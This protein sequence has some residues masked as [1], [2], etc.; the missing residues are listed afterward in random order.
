[1][2]NLLT[3]HFAAVV[4]AVV[5]AITITITVLGAAGGIIWKTGRWVGKVDSETSGV[6]EFAQEIRDNLREMRTH[7]NDIFSRLPPPRTVETGSPVR[8][9]EFGRQVAAKLQADE[10]A[11]QAAPTLAK[12]VAGKQPFEIDDFSRTY[13]AD[14]LLPDSAWKDRIAECSYEFGIDWVG[15]L[16]VMQVML[17]D[18]ILR[19]LK[20][21]KSGT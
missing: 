13:V 4:A 19:V 15:V 6:R 5:A 20:T 1:M 9:S 2:E 8:L 17:R 10:W 11:S 3:N 16:A 18:E 12:D 21:K 14:E 7:I